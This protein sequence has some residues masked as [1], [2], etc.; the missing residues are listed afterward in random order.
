MALI[1]ENG[2]IVPNADSWVTA[3]DYA[4][5][6]SSFG[7][8]AGTLAEQESA[9]RQA[10]LYIGSFEPRLKGARISREQSLCFPR[11]GVVID[12][13]TWN[14]D[15]ISRNVKLCQM[16]YAIDI[17]VFGI[18]PY[19]PPASASTGIKRERVEGAVEVEYAVTESQ[20]LSRNSTS[21]AL[22]SSLL[23]NNGLVVLGRA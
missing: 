10:A 14:D 15:E 21:R 7:F 16:Q 18:D 20:R 22:L 6:V 12:G 3:A 2:T 13:F 23:V 4:A 1:I 8:D 11:S 19:N 17:Q 9:L 5:Y